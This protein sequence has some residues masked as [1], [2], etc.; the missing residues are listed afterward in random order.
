MRR[1]PCVPSLV[2]ASFVLVSLATAVAAP[3]EAVDAVVVLGCQN[4]PEL[5]AREA[6][7][8]A[9]VAQLPA[10]GHALL[11]LSG[12]ARLGD[13]TEA[14]AMRAALERRVPAL[15]TR[16]RALEER[17]SLDTVGNAVFSALLLRRHALPP[18]P[19]VA[20][21]TSDF[22]VPRSVAFFRHVLPADA[23]VIGVP[24][25]NAARAPTAAAR[26]RA[27]EA[28]SLALSERGIFAGVPASPAA[29]DHVLVRLILEHPYYRGRTDLLRRWR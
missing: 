9:Y 20:V 14:S 16:A 1:V 23:V 13:S 7:A 22:H 5:E 25:S 2:L 4:R 18:H 15:A 19:R 12:G 11:V 21:V 3:A 24:A 29:A 10:D 6:A 28:R 27:K 8:A 17:D 26:F